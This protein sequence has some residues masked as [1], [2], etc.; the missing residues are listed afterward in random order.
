VIAFASRHSG[1]STLECHRRI[2]RMH[3]Q[4]RT[5]EMNE[6][7]YKGIYCARHF[8]V[9]SEVIAACDHRKYLMEPK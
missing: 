8:N 2:D 7:A 3:N 9:M 6:T 1:N 5:P 4:A